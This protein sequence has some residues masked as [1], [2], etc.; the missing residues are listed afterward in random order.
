MFYRYIVT[1]RRFPE[2]F[3]AL[4]ARQS[5]W[6][7]GG[8]CIKGHASIFWDTNSLIINPAKWLT[9]QPYSVSSWNC[10]VFVYPNFFKNQFYILLFFYF[11]EISFFL[12]SWPIYFAFKIIITIKKWEE[13]FF[14]FVLR[15][16]PFLS[17][18]P[19]RISNISRFVL[20]FL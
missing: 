14:I 3:A 12:T 9:S 8:L 18:S 17:I 6:G 15:G 5:K 1:M 7:G 10:F 11:S 20:F 4:S 19:L 16:L 13:V 2:F